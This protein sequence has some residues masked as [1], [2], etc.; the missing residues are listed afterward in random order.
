MAARK[1]KRKS[2]SMHSTEAWFRFTSDLL[3]NSLPCVIANY[4]GILVDE[5]GERGF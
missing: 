3:W 4:T 1:P 2:Q 5:N